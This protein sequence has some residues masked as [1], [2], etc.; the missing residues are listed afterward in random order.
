MEQNIALLRQYLEKVAPGTGFEHLRTHV[1]THKSVWATRI[2]MEHGIT[3]FKAT[4]NE[5]HMLLAAGAQDI[6]VSYS[7][8][9]HQADDLARKIAAV[10]IARVMDCPGPDR[11]TLNLGYKRWGIDAGPI[12]RF[13]QEGLEVE[14]TSEEHTV[15]KVN[16]HCKKVFQIG[17]PVLVVPHHICS[18]VNLWEDFILIGPTG[19]IEIASCPVDGRNR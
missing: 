12:Q 8:F 15:L 6:F 16:R 13:S 5:F 2:Q 1:K 7:L 9:P 3:K 14:S 18:T 17:D 4:P 10:L 11:I 19:E